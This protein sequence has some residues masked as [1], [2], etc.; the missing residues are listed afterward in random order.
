MHRTR[1]TVR[2]GVPS[3][4][5]PAAAAPVGPS[6]CYCRRWWTKLVIHMQLK[7]R[8]TWFAQSFARCVFLQPPIRMRRRPVYFSAG[9]FF[10]RTPSSVLS[11]ELSQTVQCVPK[12]AT[13]EN[14]RPKSGWSPSK[15]REKTA[16]FRVVLGRFRDLSSLISETMQVTDKI[17]C[18][19]QPKICF[20][21]FLEFGSS[22]IRAPGLCLPCP[23]LCYTT[24]LIVYVFH[25]KNLL[26][27][28]VTY[29]F[30]KLD[31]I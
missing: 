18:N 11:A 3:C 14:G 30:S 22:A 26:I 9:S 10:I 4:G 20:E 29:I 21:I 7:S 2:L 27:A 28:T 6:A 12:T 19:S 8:Q 5:Q 13:F 24:A 31:K 17:L 1:R 15:T 23:P 25:Q 16:N